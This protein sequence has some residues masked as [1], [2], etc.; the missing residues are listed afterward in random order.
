MLPKKNF[1]RL[2]VNKDCLNLSQ[3]QMVKL[4][5]IIIIIIIIIVILTTICMLR[6]EI[7]TY[8]NIVSS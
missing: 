2:S 4:I 7:A 1:S 8:L 5:I 3:N 6:I